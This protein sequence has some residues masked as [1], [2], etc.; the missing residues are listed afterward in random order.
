MPG[1][2]KIEVTLIPL[3]GGAIE[4]KTENIGEF[5]IH[6]AIGLLEIGKQQLI[7]LA[8]KNKENLNQ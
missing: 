5:S 6:E 3:E 8:I 7:K 2:K 1:Q 4:V